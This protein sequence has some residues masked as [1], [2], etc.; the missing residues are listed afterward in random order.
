MNAVLKLLGK[1]QKP[2]ESPA[3]AK[4]ER[5][6]LTCGELNDAIAKVSNVID[7]SSTCWQSIEALYG[8]TIGAANG[9]F[10]KLKGAPPISV[11]EFDEA[12]AQV[13]EPACSLP[14]LRRVRAL[15]AKE[16]PA[17]AEPVQHVTAAQMKARDAALFD[18][19][20]WALGAMASELN[21]SQPSQAHVLDMLKRSATTPEREKLLSG[22]CEFREA[23]VR[24][25]T[26]E[27]HLRYQSTGKWA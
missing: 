25:R 5:N 21:L 1:A 7:H 26:Q 20:S 27:E 15:L 23:A 2:A 17:R 12:L 13:P 11:A 19:F 8:L 3:P 9:D 18:A 4:R 16:Q 6:R 24:P 22:I 14:A 10:V